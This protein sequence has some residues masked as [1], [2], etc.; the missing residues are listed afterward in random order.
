MKTKIHGGTAI[1]GET[2]LCVTCRHSTII[3]GQTIDEEIVDCS[4]S[5]MRSRQ[6]RFKVT[7]C[8]SYSDARL[9]SYHEMVRSAWILTPQSKR[10]TA[11]FIPANQLDPAE[12]REILCADPDNSEG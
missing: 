2:S 7:S 12:L 4:A 5:F 10:R 6:I 8:S 3:R 9:P 11:G 1:H